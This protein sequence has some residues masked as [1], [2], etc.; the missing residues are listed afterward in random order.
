MSTSFHF[1]YSPRKIPGKRPT[2]L[3]VYHVPACLVLHTLR[4][5]C[6][7][8]RK[9]SFSTRWLA[10]VWMPRTNQWLKT[11][12]I[13]VCTY[14]KPF[15]PTSQP[16]RLPVKQTA[17]PSVV[18]RSLYKKHVYDITSIW[19]SNDENVHHADSNVRP[20]AFCHNLLHSKFIRVRFLSRPAPASRRG[21]L[22]PSQRA[23]GTV[24]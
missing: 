13:H 2:N 11:D 10:H 3:F 16:V 23:D 9:H 21:G 20:S 6:A 7:I 18:S 17:Q 24:M 19:F 1:I 12:I 4:A 15:Q 5:V 22:T 14:A 8:Y